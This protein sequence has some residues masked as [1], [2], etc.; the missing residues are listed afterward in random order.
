VR[1]GI[2]RGDAGAE[3]CQQRPDVV[4]GELAAAAQHRLQVGGVDEVEDQNGGAAAA[5]AKPGK[6]PAPR[7]TAK[8]RSAAAKTLPGMDDP[9][10]GV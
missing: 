2:V 1:R 9:S 3:R 7:G 6:N 8:G 10:G 5:A 4:D